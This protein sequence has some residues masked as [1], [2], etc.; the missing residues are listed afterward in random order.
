[1][2]LDPQTSPSRPSRLGPGFAAAAFLCLALGFAAASALLLVGK[3]VFMDGLP[4]RDPSRLVLLTGVHTE[5]GKAE[6]WSISQPDYIDWSKQNQVF[7]RM[8]LLAPDY[9][10][11]LIDGNRSERLNSE[12][13]SYT[14]F[15]LL[16]LEPAAGRF[17]LEE[18]DQVPYRNAVLVLS[19]DLWQRRFG[20]DPKVVGRKLDL[21]TRTYTVVGVA[22]K[23]FRGAYDKADLWVP[24]MMSPVPE[25]PTFRRLRWAAAVARLKPGVTLE[26]AQADLDRI[27]G[28]LEKRYPVDNKGMGVHVDPLDA[29]FFGGVRPALRTAAWSAA[30]LLLL[31]AATAAVLLRGRASLGS[32]VTLSLAAA[33]AGLGVA[34]W[35]VHELAPVSGFNLPSFLVLS[36]GLGVVLA[37]AAL[38]LAVGLATGLAA[39]SSASSSDTGGWRLFRGLLVTAEAA[40]AVFLMVGA[41]RAA[42]DYRAVVARDLGFQ[43]GNV[44]TM[45]ID[46][47]GPKWMPDPPVF[48]AER[49]YLDRLSK[50]DGVE[51]AALGGPSILGDSWA[52]YYV[53]LEDDPKGQ[54]DEGTWFFIVHAV[55]PEY[56]STLGVP[57]L[58]GRAFTPADTDTFG[59]IVSQSLAERHWPGQNPLGKRLKRGERIS[60]NPWLTV[61]GVV[62]DVH[63]EGYKGEE[64]PAPDVYVSL[65][66]FQVRVPLTLNVFVKPKPGVEP[67]SL[68]PAVERELRAVAPDL[69]PYDVA[70]MQE[71]LDRQVQPDRLRVLLS[72]LFAGSMLVLAAAAAWAAF[73]GRRRESAA[74]PSRL[75]VPGGT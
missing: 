35:A 19:Y 43:P 42:R 9:A 47:R 28:A 4:H 18:E 71:R 23:G 45:R 70:T 39:R 57:V 61:V 37:L 62:P 27:A 69:P 26:Q 74:V 20:G 24:S 38:A 59:A 2:N 30:L 68:R 17:F 14:Y 22:P 31:A 16:G 41:V 25:A 29:H 12:L 11:N 46:M 49:R 52:G 44:L 60:M 64:W 55:S 53:T 67:A 6:E 73:A 8:S 36:P 56:F 15:P 51:T 48:D 7:E 50:L 3:P 33:A 63:Y 32:A 40:L 34:A 66:Q 58:K 65:L 21:N 75:A 5:G 13:A 10:M 54:D 1:M 72:E